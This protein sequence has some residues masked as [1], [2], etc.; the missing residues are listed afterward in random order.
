MFI[1]VFY[2]FVYYLNNKFVFKIIEKKKIIK[3]D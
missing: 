2:K 3:N 1:D